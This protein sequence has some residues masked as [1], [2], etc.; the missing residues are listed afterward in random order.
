MGRA[1]SA[2]VHQH[3]NVWSYG[4]SVLATIE[5]HTR[6]RRGLRSRGR[7]VTARCPRPVGT[8]GRS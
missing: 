3:R 8:P 7:T 6:F 2:W 4:P 5:L 1:A